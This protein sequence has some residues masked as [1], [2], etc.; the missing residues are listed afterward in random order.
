M[1][2]EAQDRN[3]QQ[4]GY[5]IV[6]FGLGRFGAEI[7]WE[8]RQR[9]HRVLGVDF[10]PELVHRHKEDDYAVRYGDAE[11]PGFVATLPFGQVRWVLSSVREMHVNLAL[12]HGLRGYGYK[13]CVAVTAH[14]TSDAGQ[15]KRAGIGC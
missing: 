5:D 3:T 9:G 7:A 2:E 10:A 8:L 4:S 13:G 11:A 6:L 12:L 1:Q 15:L 14:T